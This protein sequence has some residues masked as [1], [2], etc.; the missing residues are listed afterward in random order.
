MLMNSVV[1]KIKMQNLRVV[2]KFGEK[3]ILLIYPWTYFESSVGTI[4][5]ITIFP[6]KSF[7]S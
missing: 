2:W 6:K 3:G 1:S 5:F 7:F 4:S